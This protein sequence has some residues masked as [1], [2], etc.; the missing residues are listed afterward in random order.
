MRTLYRF[1]LLLA[2]GSLTAL[3]GCGEDETPSLATYPDNNFS[4]V[5]ED[6]EGSEIIVN[7]TYN[8]EGILEFDKPTIFTFRFNASPEDAIVT[9]EPIGEDVELSDT[10]LIIPAG[11]TDA[12]VTLGIKNMDVFQ[13]NYDEA[14]CNLGVRAT[15]QGYKMP[16]IT[17][18]A[19]ALIKKEA[20]VATGFL[21][22]KAGNKTTFEHTYFNGEFK[23]TERNLYTF[24]VQLDRPARKDVKVK[25][26][27]EGVD[28]EYLKDIS[29]TPAEI[30]I[31]A[32]EKT[33]GDIT[34]EITNDFLLRTSD[35]SSNTLNITAVFE[36]E[37]PVFVQDEKRSS[38]TLNINK[39]IRG[40]E[41]ISY[42]RPSG[43]IEWAKQGWS[44]DVEDSSDFY[45]ND[46]GGSLIDGETQG[47]YEGICSDGD[48]SFTLD[49]GEEKTITGVGLDY[50]YYYAPQNVQLSV[51][52]DGNTWNYLGKVATVDENADYYQFIEPITARYVKFDLLASWGCE[53]YEIYVF[54]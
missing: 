29:I 37:D 39:Y 20:Y 4:L 50:I 31:P 1:F 48:I 26:T 36:C 14:T 10:K 52:S 23:D 28:D 53:L 18:E 32:G 45:Q 49:M 15:V 2:V 34:W 35:D 54:K 47:N 43:W 19:K 51:S 11:Y 8:N 17:L 12:S 41:H 38:F 40:F 30:I 21:E 16:S 42:K 44:V 33:S 13:S 24:S 6:G 22:G 3:S 9:F 27:T 46:G 5:A 7:A 25:L